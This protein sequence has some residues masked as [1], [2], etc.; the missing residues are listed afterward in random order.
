MTKKYIK[1]CT[2]DHCEIDNGQSGIFSVVIFYFLLL[3]FLC[4]S[5]YILF[6]SQYLKISNVSIAGTQQ[7]S[8]QEI[9]QS[10]DNLLGGKF[11]NMIPRNNFLF[12]SQRNI[13]NKVKDDLKKIRGVFVSKKFPDTVSI[14]ID[15][16]KA[17]L[18]WCGAQKCYLLD[19]QGFAYSEAD[20]SSEQLIQNNLLQINDNSGSEIKIGEKIIEPSFEQYVLALKDDLLKFGFDANGQYYTPSRMSEEITMKTNQETDFYFSTQFS[21]ESAIKTLSTIFKKE[22][23]AE[24]RGNIAYIDLRNENKVFYKLKIIE[25]VAP[26]EPVST[27]LVKKDEK[28]K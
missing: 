28:K 6:F 26:G 19:E 23:P 11:L 15:E 3:C 24:K 12:I 10:I 27:V 16:R 9:K 7:L 13:E 4:V 17:L 18:V 25:P 21:K 1:N 5:I 8:D 2:G 22:I 14:I 20:F